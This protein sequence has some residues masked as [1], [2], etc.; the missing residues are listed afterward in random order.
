MMFIEEF[1]ITQC[2]SVLDASKR[3]FSHFSGQ[4]ENLDRNINFEFGMSYCL[5][6]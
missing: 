2:S 6:K 4:R 5:S 3:R 1:N